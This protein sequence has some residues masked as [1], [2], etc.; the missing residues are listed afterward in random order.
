MTHLKIKDYQ[1]ALMVQDAANLSGVVHSF[2]EV[3]S[4]IWKEGL[5][6]GHGTKYVNHHP[7]TI[8]YADKIADLS[9]SKDFKVYTAAYQKC[10]KEVKGN[11]V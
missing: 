3:V 11:E 6:R 10:V 4:K 9:G 7:I 2:S 8:L 1:D 5:D